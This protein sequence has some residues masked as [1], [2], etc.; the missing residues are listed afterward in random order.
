[1][2]LGATCYADAE[3]ALSIAL[4]LAR[5]A[6]GGIE[7]VLVRD[8][9]VLMAASHHRVRIVSYS[10]TSATA[11]TGEAMLLAYQSDARRFEERLSG[12]AREAR[13][14]TGFRAIEGHLAE[15]VEEMVTAGDI[16]VLGVRRAFGDSGSVVVISDSDRALPAFAAPL[17]A[18]L[19]KRLIVLSPAARK[20]QAA[21]ASAGEDMPRSGSPGGLPAETLVYEGADALLRR[22]DA[23]SPAA[24]IVAAGTSDLPALAQLVDAARCPVILGAG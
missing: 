5:Q 17:A 6:G 24:V 23:L 2:V 11:T 10:G 9:N 12:L 4:A 18:S 3:A 15:A 19:G 22:L 21:Q 14:A 20:R 7:G 8:E 1:V 16:A 13:I